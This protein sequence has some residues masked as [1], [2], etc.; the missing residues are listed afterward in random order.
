MYR[1]TE[2]PRYCQ[3]DSSVPNG[4]QGTKEIEAQMRINDRTERGRAVDTGSQLVT[5]GK[6]RAITDLTYRFSRNTP[7]RN[8]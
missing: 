3:A 5:L 2:L 7:I 8:C 1:W 4:L 6:M